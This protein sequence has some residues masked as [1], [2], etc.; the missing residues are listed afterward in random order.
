LIINS[1]IAVEKMRNG[2]NP[3]EAAKMALSRIVK[4]YPN[5]SGALIAVNI[6]GAYGAACHGLPNGFPFSVRTP[7]LDQ[8]LVKTIQCSN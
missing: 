5:F 6:A 7:E 2:A 3:E 4:F 1:L 8:V